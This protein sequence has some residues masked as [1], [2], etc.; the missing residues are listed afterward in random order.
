MFAFPPLIGHSIEHSLP[1]ERAGSYCGKLSKTPPAGVS[2]VL[3]IDIGDRLSTRI[4]VQ[5]AENG[6]GIEQLGNKR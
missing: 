3:D 1:R 4:K 6:S 5:K 2:T